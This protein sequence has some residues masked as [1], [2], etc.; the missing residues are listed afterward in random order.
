MLP[1]LRDPD[2]GESE[3]GSKGQDPVGTLPGTTNVYGNTLCVRGVIYPANSFVMLSA[4][5]SGV[6]V[7]RVIVRPA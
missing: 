1:L 6:K 3:L 5:V 2:S 4:P 7:D